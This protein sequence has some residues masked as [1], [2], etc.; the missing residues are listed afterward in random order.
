MLLFKDVYENENIW[1]NPKQ[2][3]TSFCALID[4]RTS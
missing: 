1:L 4:I 2:L 3:I